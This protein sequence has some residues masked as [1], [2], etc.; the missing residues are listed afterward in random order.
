MQP[1]HRTLIVTAMCALAI[2][3]CGGARGPSHAAS[4]T[5]Y[6]PRNSPASMSRCM[7]A[8][9]LSNF[10]DPSAGPGGVGFRGVEVPIG[11]TGQELIVDGI[12]FS[13]PAYVKAAQA[14]KQFL[15]GGGGPPPRVSAARKA[16][17]LKAAAC[18][19]R[20]GVPNFPDPT[21]PSSGGLTQNLPPGLSLQSPAFERALQA[22]SSS[23]AFGVPS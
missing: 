17:M 21:F 9:G 5:P 4:T 22:C 14:C 7:R 6:G 20:H 23:R 3:A 19:R 13:G 1:A 18:I 11:E 15:P 8:H 2:A 10:P 16:Q 12:T